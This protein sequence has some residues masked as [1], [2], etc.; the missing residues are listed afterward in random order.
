VEILSFAARKSPSG[1]MIRDM[2]KGAIIWMNEAME[3]IIG[4]TLEELK[5]KVGIN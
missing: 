5:G 1:I 2:P 4:Y 3:H